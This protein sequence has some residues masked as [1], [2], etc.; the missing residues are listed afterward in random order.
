MEEYKMIIGV[1]ADGVLTDLADF[2]YKCGE[3]FFKRKPS[4]SSGYSIS[5]MFQSTSQ[6]EFLFGLKYFI[7]YC[8]N[9]LP[10]EKAAETI[11]R[12]NA[13]GHTLIEITARKFVMMRN[14]IGRYS[15]SMFENWLGKYGF[16]FDNIIY[17]S[18]RNTGREKY[19]ACIKN[20]VDVMIDDRPEVALY[21]AEHQIK[22]L[23]FDA[24][25]NQNLEHENVRRV[26]SWDDVYTKICDY[27]VEND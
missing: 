1:D 23:L 4:C 20:K 14:P 21:L 11:S 25:Y 13:E 5:Q 26:K 10:R 18:E 16:E 7:H 15:R 27:G 3:K 2:Q 8:K 12:L 22:V 17:C 19:E 9:W 24:P 6:Q